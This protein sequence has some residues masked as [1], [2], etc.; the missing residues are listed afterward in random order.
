[1]MTKRTLLLA[2]A[3]ALVAGGA[4]AQDK[5]KIGAAPYGSTPS[6]CRSGSPR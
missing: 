6:S 4:M 1:M 5:I 3:M 2:T